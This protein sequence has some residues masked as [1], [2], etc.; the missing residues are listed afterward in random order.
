MGNNDPKQ[1]KPTPLPARP[2][3]PKDEKPTPSKPKPIFEGEDD[4]RGRRLNG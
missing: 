3:P 1:E 2:T 4:R